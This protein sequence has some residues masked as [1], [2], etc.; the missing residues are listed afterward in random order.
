MYVCVYQHYSFLLIFSLIP[1]TLP[2]ETKSTMQAN[3]MDPKLALAKKN[4]VHPL[5]PV[6]THLSFAFT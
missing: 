5:L 1:K 4:M 2:L 3:M 6:N